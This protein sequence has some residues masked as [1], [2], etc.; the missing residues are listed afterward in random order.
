MIL[1]ISFLAAVFAYLMLAAFM[2]HGWQVGGRGPVLLAATAVSIVWAGGGAFV[3]W[4]LPFYGWL[5]VDGLNGIRVLAW[6]AVCHAVACELLPAPHGYSA[7]TVQGRLL[8]IGSALLFLKLSFLTIDV[9][10]PFQALWLQLAHVAGLGLAVLGLVFVE[11]LLRAADQRRRWVIKHLMLAVGAI[12][13]FDVFYYSDLLLLRQASDI[14]MGGQAWLSVFAVPLVAVA[15]ARIRYF[16]INIQISR[17]A[18]LQ[19]SAL[20]GCGLYLLAVA[21]AAYALRGLGWGWGPTLQLAFVTGAALLL[22]ILLSSGQLRDQW[23][24]LI[25]RSFFSFAYD[26]RK[27]WQ[28]L[29]RTMDEDAAESLHQRLV[30][31]A[32]DPFDCSGGMVYLR[33]RDGGFRHQADWNWT[34]NELPPT[35]SDSTISTV[36]VETPSRDL[37]EIEGRAALG[38]EDAWL[39]LALHA[40]GRRLGILVLGKPR[41]WRKLTW[42]DYEFLDMLAAQ[43]GSYLAEEQMSKALAE[44]QRFEQMSK[45][46]SFV[47][48]DLKNIVSQLGLHLRQAERHGTNP[49]FMADTMETV[50]DSVEKMKAML[51]RLNRKED[52]SVLEMTDLRAIIKDVVERKRGGRHTVAMSEDSTSLPARVDSAAFSTVIDNLIQNAFDAGGSVEVKAGTSSDGQEAM[53][54]IIDDGQGMTECF[55]GEHLFQPFTSTKTE[56]FGIGMY[57]ARSWIESWQGRMTV[58]SKPQLGTTVHI[59]LPIAAA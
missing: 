17:E 50:K 52:S 18:V 3:G 36:T 47:A 41:I 45:S 8:Q 49:E 12:F 32:A 7:A 35:L 27:E 40:R 54:S 38:N 19:T 13:A 31:A 53:I 55:I 59:H 21:L 6:I 28:R 16:R 22:V 57:Q 34:R 2:V 9:I 14:S 30:R 58:E 4:S 20:I 26:Y 37:R 39:L 1:I 42:E 48:H 23:R 24:R 10:R 11:T 15:T 25:T 29:I 44:A 5:T 33:Q 46:F 51:L 43:L 56:G